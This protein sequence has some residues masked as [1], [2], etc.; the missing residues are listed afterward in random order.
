MSPLNAR[1][2]AVFATIAVFAVSGAISATR[3]ELRPADR[4]AVIAANDTTQA[5]IARAMRRRP[6]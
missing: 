4:T 2:T 3:A 6:R 5:K 1:Q